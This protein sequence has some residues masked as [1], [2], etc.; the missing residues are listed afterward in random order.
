MNP[1]LAEIL[2]GAGLSDIVIPRPKFIAEHKRLI[3]LLNSSDDPALKKEAKDQSEELKMEGGFSKASGFIRRLMAEN[4]L[5]HKG[6]YK[7]PTYPLHPRS[8]MDKPAEFEYNKLANESQ[9]GT[10]EKEYGDRKSVV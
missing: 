6:Q 2:H 5:K 3:K 10:N 7:K 1:I 4:V 9:R 8:N